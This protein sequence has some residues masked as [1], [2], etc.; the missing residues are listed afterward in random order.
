M[1]ISRLFILIMFSLPLFCN[2]QISLDSDNFPVSG[3]YLKRDYA[4]PLGDSLGNPGPSQNYNFSKAWIVMSDSIKYLDALSTPFI[5]EHPGTKVVVYTNDGKSEW[6]HYYNYDNNAFWESGI[7]VIADFG[8]GLDTAHGNYLPADF[9]TI[10]SSKFSYGY[11]TAQKSAVTVFLNPVVSAKLSKIK[12]ISADGWGTLKTPVDSFPD[13]LRVKFIE[14]KYDSIFVLGAFY[15]AS[16]DTLYYYNY[17]ASNMRHPVMVAHTDEGDT[18]D[19][20]EIVHAPLLI[21]GCTDTNSVNYNP[22]ANADD[23]S[24][25]YCNPVSYIITPDTNICSGDSVI[26]EINGGNS[27]YWS[28]G[29]TTSSVTIKPD[30]DTIYS[31]YVSDTAKCWELATIQVNVHHQTEAEFWVNP[32]SLIAG[33][34]IQFI[35]TSMNATDYMWTFDDAVNN[36]SAEKNPRH[37]YSINGQKNVTLV[38]SNICYSD[39]FQLQLNILAGIN[40]VYC[41]LSM[42]KIYPNPADENTTVKFVITDNTHVKIIIYDLLGSK[43]FEICNRDFI[44]GEYILSVD[45]GNLMHGVYIVELDAGEYSLKRKFIK[46][47]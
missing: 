4:I 32:N 12:N 21:Y 22:L 39:T 36:T 40:E 18:L 24:C 29:E 26:L 41:P 34:S 31:V 11:N 13:I 20:L 42:F 1:K 8:S 14:Y 19:Y 17:Y 44:K 28:N 7:T 38:A 47:K 27:W 16:L 2:A 23:G 43:I 9:D 6:C 5:A 33:D 10:V 30:T 15:S 35:N 46:V 3:L 25:I 37:L 45:I